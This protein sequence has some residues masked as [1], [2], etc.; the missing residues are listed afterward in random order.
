MK[1]LKQTGQFKKDLKRIQN[2]PR[3]LFSLNVVIDLLRETGTVPREY[4]PH[5]LTGNY[6]GYMECH[7]GSDFLLIWIAER[8][9]VIKLVRWGSNSE[10]C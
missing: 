2:N 8:D 3:K 5:L 10:L 6:R 7:I 4:Y 9:D 1:R